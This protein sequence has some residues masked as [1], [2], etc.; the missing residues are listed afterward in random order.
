MNKIAND[1]FEGDAEFRD[2]VTTIANKQMA[3]RK[4]DYHALAIMEPEDLDQEIWCDLFESECAD[5]ESLKKRV[6]DFAEIL[7]CRGRW[8]RSATGESPL[9]QLTEEQRK[10]VEN[11][12][13]SSDYEDDE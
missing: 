3:R 8:E 7:A 9:S 1:L 4:K 12:F 13:Y 2:Y 5:K 6:N 10:A 11:I